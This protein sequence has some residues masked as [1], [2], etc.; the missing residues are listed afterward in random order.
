MTTRLLRSSP[1]GFALTTCRA[2]EYPRQSR[3][4]AQCASWDAEVNEVVVA[5]ILAGG[6]L[7]VEAFA[8]AEI[9]GAILDRSDISVLDAQEQ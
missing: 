7:L 2:D 8:A 1:L 4:A 5:G 9:V 3:N 6:A